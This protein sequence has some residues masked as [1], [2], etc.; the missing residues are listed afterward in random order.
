VG[1]WEA[2]YRSEAVGVWSLIVVPAVFLLALPFLRPR[3]PGA[4]PR[5]ARFV[6]AWA[7]AFGLATIVDPLATGLAGMPMLP[8]VLLGDLRVFLLV[9][10]VME[11]AAPLARTFLQAAAWTLVVPAVTLVVSRLVERA[12]GPQPEQ[13]LWLIYECAFTALAL[14]WRTRRVGGDRF[15]RAVLAYVVTYYALW[16]LSDVLI[17]SGVDA[18]WALRI[19]PNQLFYAFWVPVVWALFFSPRYAST[20]SVVQA[21][22]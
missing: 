7:V 17:L 16:V 4:E 19:V 9:L 5:A 6:R 2:L 3:S 22:R 15:L 13:I 21:R 1:P 14:W 10:G 12:T 20:S 18:G 11:P 8:F